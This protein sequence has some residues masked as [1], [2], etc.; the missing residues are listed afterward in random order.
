MRVRKSRSLNDYVR[1][2]WNQFQ[3]IGCI[4]PRKQTK[5]Q[6]G[7]N[8]SLSSFQSPNSPKSHQSEVVTVFHNTVQYDWTKKQNT[9]SRISLLLIS[10]PP[11]WD[12]L[13]CCFS[14]ISLFRSI[15]T[16]EK[17]RP[18]CVGHN[19]R[20]SICLTDLFTHL[21]ICGWICYI[22]WIAPSLGGGR[23]ILSSTPSA[24]HFP[25]WWKLFRIGAN[26]LMKENVLM[27][28]GRSCS[29]CIAGSWYAKQ[30][31]VWRPQ[32]NIVRVDPE[33]CKARKNRGIIAVISGQLH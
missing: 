20:P 33:H 15:E 21:L 22:S 18:L 16:C 32:K 28:D 3:P 11:V 5:S 10:H 13:P 26:G 7:R 17:K 8:T 30:I 6:H 2:G 23:R 4:Q 12:L 31:W 14:S 9:D 27:V 24:C 19:F 29:V 1:T 25:R